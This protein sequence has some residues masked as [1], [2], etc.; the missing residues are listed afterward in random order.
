[1]AAN[2]ASPVRGQDIITD[3]EALKTIAAELLG[4]SP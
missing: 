1:M 3:A 2:L 4:I